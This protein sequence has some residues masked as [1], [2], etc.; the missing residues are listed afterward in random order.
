VPLNSEELPLDEQLEQ[1]AAGITMHLLLEPPEL[2][3]K[4]LPPQLRVVKG[5]PGINNYCIPKSNVANIIMMGADVYKFFHHFTRA[6][7]AYFLQS[8][9]GGTR[10]SP[11]WPA[12]CKAVANTLDWMSSPAKAP[13]YLQFE[14]SPRQ[15]QIAN[16]FAAYAFR[17]A[18]CH[19][20]A[21][22]ILGHLESKNTAR[23]TVSGEDVEFLRASQQQE[24]EA[25]QVGLTIQMRSLP[26]FSQAEIALASSIYFVH[27]TAL[28]DARLMLL[29]HLV[30][31]YHWKIA[32]THPPY[33]ARMF[34]LSRQAEG[35]YSGGAAGLMKVHESLQ[36]VQSEIFD[37]ANRQQDAV[38]EA[39]TKLV[40]EVKQNSGITKENIPAK[41][42]DELL[43]LF[44][45]SPCGVMRVLEPQSE[46][47]ETGDEA[48]SIVVERLVSLLP[49]EFRRFHLLSKA[50]RASEI[51]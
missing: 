51:A 29:A 22:I 6:A 14:L 8:E 26:N 28:L 15:S 39:A 49:D 33:L 9:P 20:M 24:F 16:A 32:L 30:D 31:V 48:R 18:L 43:R 10:P 50:E 1:L 44:D 45:Q 41:V 2:K 38:V 7:A 4:L 21:H 25:D 36:A 13:R 35:L 42:R 17:F 37:T 3:D 34:T 23:R 27:I 46:T 12:A 5:P 11:F 40:N 47:A 19:E